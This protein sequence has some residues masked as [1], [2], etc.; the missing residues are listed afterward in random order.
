MCSI[1]FC[2]ISADDSTLSMDG[3]QDKPGS[4]LAPGLPVVCLQAKE[5]EPAYFL[6]ASGCA[7][8]SVTDH[9]IM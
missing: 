9:K 5:L 2:R 1:C 8:S 4:V 6:S 3:S 7:S